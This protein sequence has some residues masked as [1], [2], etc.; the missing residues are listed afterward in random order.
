MSERGVVTASP[1]EEGYARDLAELG[2]S[3]P[4]VFTSS[5]L[6]LRQ[7]GNTSQESARPQTTSAGGA[8]VARGRHV[9]TCLPNTEAGRRGSEGCGR[10]LGGTAS[11]R[12]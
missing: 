5:S 8:A 3:C 4:V 2:R 6:A 12:L 1:L 10:G 9:T 11:E 7:R